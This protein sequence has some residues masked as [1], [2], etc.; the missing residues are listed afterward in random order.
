MRHALRYRLSLPT[1][2]DNRRLE[3]RQPA[4]S[5]DQTH[6]LTSAPVYVPPYLRLCDSDQSYCSPTANHRA[7]EGDHMADLVSKY[8]SAHA[9][10]TRLR[11]QQVALKAQN[12]SLSRHLT[13]QR[14]HLSFT[15]RDRADAARLSSVVAEQLAQMEASHERFIAVHYSAVCGLRRDEYRKLLLDYH[16]T[17]KQLRRLFS[18]HRESQYKFQQCIF[19]MAVG[20]VKNPPVPLE[21][22][23]SSPEPSTSATPHIFSGTTSPLL[24]AG[25]LSQFPDPGSFTRRS[26]P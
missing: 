22:V 3:P 20:Y 15:F 5:V 17:Q 12:Q 8:I 16:H 13:L 25:T 1:L 9:H 10:A 19:Q 14:S 24:S 23:S 6:T 21:Q 4:L 11:D 18:S 26:C 2:F 7:H